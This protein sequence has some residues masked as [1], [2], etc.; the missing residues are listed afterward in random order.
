M[1]RLRACQ[2][3][4]D[5]RFRA[6]QEP[7]A[8]KAM[9]LDRRYDMITCGQLHQ[10]KCTQIGSGSGPG[11]PWRLTRR[12]G[13][14]AVPGATA[15]PWRPRQ[16]LD[17]KGGQ[18]QDQTRQRKPDTR[19]E[20]R[21]GRGNKPGKTFFSPYA[22]ITRRIARTGP[23]TR[24]MFRGIAMAKRKVIDSASRSISIVQPESTTVGF[25][26]PRNTTAP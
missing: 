19:Q 11:E 2:T 12:A 7:L 4:L 14:W 20:P 13:I 23:E 16:Y 10:G 1:E 5:R 24:I 6:L 3:G 21:K 15:P 8:R 22:W 17:A 26:A 25:L 18:K 9:R